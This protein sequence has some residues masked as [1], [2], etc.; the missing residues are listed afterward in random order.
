ME[1]IGHFT[2]ASNI[3]MTKFIRGKFAPYVGAVFFFLGW[4]MVGWKMSL[5]GR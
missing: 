2:W 4:K 5:G 1:K 3:S